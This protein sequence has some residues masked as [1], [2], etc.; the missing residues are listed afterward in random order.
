MSGGGRI[1]VCGEGALDAPAHPGGGAGAVSWARGD[2]DG[3]GAV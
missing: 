3:A 1:C 2:D